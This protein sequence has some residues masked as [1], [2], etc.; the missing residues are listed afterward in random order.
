MKDKFLGFL[1]I[2]EIA[3]DVYMGAILVTDEYSVPVEFRVTVPVKPT[4]IQKAIYGDAMVPYIGTEL[5]GTQLL[6]KITHN[7]DVVLVSPRYMLNLRSKS[8]APVLYIYDGTE[9]TGSVVMED[10]QVSSASDNEHAFGQLHVATAY[11]FDEDYT[12]VAPLLQKV[13]NSFDLLEPF[14][15]IDLAVEVLGKEDPR[16]SGK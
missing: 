16:F 1:K 4:T 2:I 7:L 13:S 3:D 15:R 6:D 9:L 12:Q 11:R 5:C 8:T 14:N 10:E